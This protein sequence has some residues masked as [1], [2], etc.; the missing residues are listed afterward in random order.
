M[1]PK[2]T[3]QGLGPD[4]EV[5]ISSLNI[6]SVF[7]ENLVTSVVHSFHQPQP[8]IAFSSGNRIWNHCYD[9][10]FQTILQ[11]H[12]PVR[13]ILIKSQPKWSAWQG[14]RFSPSS[15]KLLA[16][17]KRQNYFDYFFCRLKQ[18]DQS[19]MK[20]FRGVAFRGNISCLLNKLLK[21]K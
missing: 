16:S 12:C 15:W 3:I 6:V 2:R 19:W 13:L 8:Q 20:T 10:H 7:L 18:A 1:L 14:I 4:I 9:W 11:L 21:G 17:Q 5:S